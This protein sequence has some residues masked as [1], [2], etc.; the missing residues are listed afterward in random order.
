MTVAAWIQ[1]HAFDVEWQTIISK[2]DT[3]WRLSRG[4]GRNI[5]F[6]CTGLWPEWV[7][8]DIEI[9]DG[10]W[11]HVAG[12]Y[13]GDELRLYVDGAVDVSAATSVLVNGNDYAV[14]LGENAEH[15][16]REWNGLID[17]V[18]LYSYALSQEEIRT[19]YDA[20]AQRP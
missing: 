11:H 12:T 7:H 6:G 18:R 20:G 19:L 16:G 3:A 5:H 8:G 17:D 14:F 13:D 1:V 9:D 10:Q 15:P 4:M 2:G